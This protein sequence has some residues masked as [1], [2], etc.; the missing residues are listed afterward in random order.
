MVEPMDQLSENFDSDLREQLRPRSAPLGFADRVMA[1]VAADRAPRPVRFPFGRPLWR[2]AAVAALVAVTVLGG[3]EHDRQ[4][5]IAGQQA[6]EQ[7]LLALRITGLTLRQV[8]QKVDAQ[9]KPLSDKE[10]QSR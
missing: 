1:R 10:N 4:Q 9:E 8:Q 2:W 3:L 5:R 6:R 7:V